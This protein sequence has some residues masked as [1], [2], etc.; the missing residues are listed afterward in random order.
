MGVGVICGLLAGALW[1]L[2]FLFPR[3]LPEF[4]AAEQM[5]GRYLAFGFVSCLLCWPVWRQLRLRLTRADVNALLKLSLVGNVMYFFCVAL[6][7]RYAGVAPASLVVGILPIT[8]TLASAWR[9]PYSALPHPPLALKQL[10]WPMVVVAAGLVCINVDAFQHAKLEFRTYTQV[11]LGVT[12][13]LA[14]LACWTYFAVANA[15]YL[16]TQRHF[17][18]HE[19]NNLT[20][21]MTGA[22]ALILLPWVMSSS[23]ESATPRP[24]NFFILMCFT[25]ALGASVIG[26][27]LWNV[28][29]RRLPITLTGQLIV[30][31]TVF[32]LLYGFV[33]AQRWP[34]L[35]EWA[36]VMLLICGVWWAVKRHAA[37]PS[38]AHNAKTDGDI[39]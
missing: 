38:L 27:A 33:H 24:W 28:A 6:A 35:L 13:A 37:A 21:L 1:G 14:A 39:G 3:L 16:Q 22:W 8:I 26:A 10:L 4:S 18:S 23:P 12:S 9:P 17:S 30:S 25:M 20:G 29:S 31:E 2:I 32:A 19:W 7:V 5:T 34:R 15:R 36:A 11:A